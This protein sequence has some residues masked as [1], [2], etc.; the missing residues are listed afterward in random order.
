MWLPHTLCG[1]HTGPVWLPHREKCEGHSAG[2][3]LSKKCG[4]L[5]ASEGCRKELQRVLIPGASD[6][7]LDL[8][9]HDALLIQPAVTVYPG[10]VVENNRKQNPHQGYLQ[11]GEEMLL[12]GHDGVLVVC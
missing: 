5:E 12:S 3:D 4:R 6:T 2:A 7:S 10:D 9:H 1:S 8:F 11:E